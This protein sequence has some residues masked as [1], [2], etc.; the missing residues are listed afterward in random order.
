MAETINMTA[1]EFFMK[2]SEWCSMEVT[3]KE[4]ALLNRVLINILTEFGERGSPAY[5]CTIL[6]GT[7]SIWEGPRMRSDG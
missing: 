3:L 1:E 4:A 7:K 2:W 5:N 6:N